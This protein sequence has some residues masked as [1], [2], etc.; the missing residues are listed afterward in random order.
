MLCTSLKQAQNRPHH[1]ISL[2]IASQ[3]GGAYTE[4]CGNMQKLPPDDVTC[5][6]HLYV[7]VTCASYNYKHIS[8]PFPVLGEA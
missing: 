1:I 8:I 6:H 2:F 3:G 7:L 5:T 4:V